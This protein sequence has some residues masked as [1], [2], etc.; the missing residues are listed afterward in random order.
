MPFFFM[1]K[2]SMAWVNLV[3]VKFS[4]HQETMAVT[5]VGD[6]GAS[7]DVEIDAKDIQTWPGQWE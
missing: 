1:S 3:K 6:G 5:R 4:W 2:N 7:H